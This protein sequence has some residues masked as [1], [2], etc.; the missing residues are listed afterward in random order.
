MNRRFHDSELSFNNEIA[1][2]CT[3]RTAIDFALPGN[4]ARAADLPAVEFWITLRRHH[5]MI[6]RIS[7]R[8]CGEQHYGRA[9]PAI[10][11][12]EMPGRNDI[13]DMM[14]AL[15]ATRRKSITRRA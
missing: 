12:G 9:P 1:N 8:R 13:A 2:I 3:P 11:A 15:N 5:R 6:P 4:A 10:T 7:S 14:Y